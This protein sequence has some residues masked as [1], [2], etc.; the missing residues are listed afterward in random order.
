MH[1]KS[2]SLEIKKQSGWRIA[3]LLVLS[4]KEENGKIG[5]DSISSHSKKNNKIILNSLQRFEVTTL[6]KE[7][8]GVDKKQVA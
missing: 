4:D 5:A 6:I 2:S 7:Y 1:Q 8:L 3:T